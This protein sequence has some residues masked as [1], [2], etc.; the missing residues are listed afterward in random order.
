[1]ESKWYWLREAVKRG[2]GNALIAWP[3]VEVLFLL[4]HL[5]ACILI[6]CCNHKNCHMK[7]CYWFRAQNTKRVSKGIKDTYSV[8]YRAASLFRNSLP[9]DVGCSN[10]QKNHPVP[11]A[12]E[13]IIYFKFIEGG[14]LFSPA[15]FLDLCMISPK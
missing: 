4:L 14:G 15:N 1:M 9:T 5:E 12:N 13:K 7:L 6:L 11:F 3:L 2:G 8:N 10:S